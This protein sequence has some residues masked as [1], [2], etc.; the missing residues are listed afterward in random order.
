MLHGTLQKIQYFDH[1][2]YFSAQEYDSPLAFKI[3]ESESPYHFHGPP[4]AY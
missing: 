3:I 1:L 2:M 4:N